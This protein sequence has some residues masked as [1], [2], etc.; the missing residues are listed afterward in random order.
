MAKCLPR[1]RKRIEIACGVLNDVA[2]LHPLIN[3]VPNIIGP[4]YG[5]AW[6]DRGLKVI[7]A[8]EYLLTGLELA[9]PIADAGATDAPWKNQHIRAFNG[10]AALRQRA[11]E[12]PILID[13]VPNTA[14]GF[15]F[16]R[17]TPNEHICL[18][19]DLIRL[20]RGLLAAEVTLANTFGATHDLRRRA[21][22]AVRTLLH[23]RNHLD[24]LVAQECPERVQERPTAAIYFGTETVS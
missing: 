23:L 8:L 4:A 22:K 13:D 18:G 1:D 9:L 15:K 2:W 11:G 7:R 20:H 10:R 6:C 21:A 17:L 12:P 14:R 16:P 3:P 5:A 19:A 24:S